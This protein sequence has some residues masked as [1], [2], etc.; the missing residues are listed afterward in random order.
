LAIVIDA[1]PVRLPRCRSRIVRM[2]LKALASG[3]RNSAGPL[4]D[5]TGSRIFRR[6][7]FCRHALN[8]AEST[9]RAPGSHRVLGREHQTAAVLTRFAIIL[10]RWTARRASVSFYGGLCGG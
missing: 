6:L 8:P 7:R 4:K 5:Q 9:E 1:R 3:A 2:V 10:G